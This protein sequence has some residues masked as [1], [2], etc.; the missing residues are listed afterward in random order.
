MGALLA[1]SIVSSG[2]FVIVVHLPKRLAMEAITACRQSPQQLCNVQM[3]TQNQAN[4]PIETN[5]IIKR[6]A[7]C[8]GTCRE[9]A[10]WPFRRCTTTKVNK[11]IEKATAMSF[12]YR[13]ITNAK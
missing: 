11:D 8:A 5:E 12:R 6:E 2:S 3:I 4:T 10:Q 13:N 7:K 9:G 1:S